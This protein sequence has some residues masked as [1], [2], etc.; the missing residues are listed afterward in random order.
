MVR[1]KYIESKGAK[2]TLLKYLEIDTSKIDKVIKLES[3]SKETQ[4]NILN[5]NP[6]D[7]KDNQ[8]QKT[9]EIK[10]TTLPQRGIKR[11]TIRH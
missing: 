11:Y 2:P 4:D 9:E 3:L 10:R 1:R 8:S 5:K 7:S 6:Q